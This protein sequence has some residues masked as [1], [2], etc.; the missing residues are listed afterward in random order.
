MYALLAAL[1]LLLHPSLVLSYASSSADNSSS[2]IAFR[3]AITIDDA[4]LTP[5]ELLLGDALGLSL[6]KLSL[7]WRIASLNRDAA[8][9]KNGNVYSIVLL[10]PGNRIA[11]VTDISGTPFDFNSTASAKSFASVVA[12]ALQANE[13]LL[14]AS[15]TFSLV[16]LLNVSGGDSMSP[17][18]TYFSA[19]AFN[20]SSTD[21]VVSSLLLEFNASYVGPGHQAALLAGF[22]LKRATVVEADLTGN[23]AA[24]AG[25]DDDGGLSSGVI[26]GIVF[27]GVALVAMIGAYFARKK[28][29]YH[30]AEFVEK[31]GSPIQS[32][33]SPLLKHYQNL[34]Q[35][36]KA[37]QF[38]TRGG[39]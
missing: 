36:G 16:L 10:L 8:M 13:T 38:R 11:P 20:T 27:A 25:D 31:Y 23:N 21:A 18:G 37:P 19:K 17:Y 12:T 3:T 22:G 29:Q 9:V 1:L 24:P 28:I 15:F 34:E 39:Q 30:D 7:Y 35:H 5:L 26:V 14:E 4:R 33:E 32:H 6:T 2:A